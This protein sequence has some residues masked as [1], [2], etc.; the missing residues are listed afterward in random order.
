[1]DPSIARKRWQ[2]RC[3]RQPISTRRETNFNNCPSPLNRGGG[4]VSGIE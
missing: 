2:A 1:L 4:L 3:K